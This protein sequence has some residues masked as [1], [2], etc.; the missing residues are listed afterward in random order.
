M[1]EELSWGPFPQFE[2]QRMGRGGELFSDNS[3]FLV[4]LGCGAVNTRGM[5]I[6]D[7]DGEY[8]M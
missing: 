7:R 8:L 3:G 6:E 5:G 4:W 1:E 2:S